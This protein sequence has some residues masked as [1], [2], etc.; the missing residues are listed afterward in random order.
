MWYNE[1]T[2]WW[3]VKIKLV[4]SNSL[5]LCNIIY[6]YYSRHI[7][8]SCFDQQRILRIWDNICKIQIRIL[9]NQCYRWVKSDVGNGYSISTYSS[10]SICEVNLNEEDIWLGN[11]DK[12]QP[13]TTA[14]KINKNKMIFAF[15]FSLIFKFIIMVEINIKLLI[16]E[17][18]WIIN[19]Y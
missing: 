11:R 12:G 14:A 17:Y 5:I 6:F 18:I 13:K 7:D 8:G 9:L 16:K 2:W 15:I 4:S 1:F 19:N 10:I 3:K